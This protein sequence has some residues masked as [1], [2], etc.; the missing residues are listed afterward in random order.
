MR[1][2]TEA[3][4]EAEEEEQQTRGFVGPPAGRL[5]RFADARGDSCSFIGG[6]QAL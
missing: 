1:I 3:A 5:L 4:E 2:R 6:S